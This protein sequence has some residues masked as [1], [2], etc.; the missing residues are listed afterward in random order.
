MNEILKRSLFGGIYVA[1]LLAATLF[2]TYTTFAL[3]GVMSVICFFEL[4]KMLQPAGGIYSTTLLGILATI[5]LSLY[6]FQEQQ[7]LNI[8]ASLVVGILL[9]FFQHVLAKGS[10]LSSSKVSNS[11]FSFGYIGLP[12]SLTPWLTIDSYYYFTPVLLVGIM[13]IIWSNDTFAYLI[14]RSFGKHRLHER[15]SPKKSVEG[16]IGGWIFA[17]LAGYIFYTYSN[18][19]YTLTDWLIFSSFTTIGGTF[20]DLFESA[21][22]RSAKVKDS[23][24]FIPGHG[25]LLDRI[26]SLLFV[27]PMV[28]LYLL[29]L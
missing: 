22:K 5:G 18:T 9:F 6:Q 7:E 25:G 27:V 28:W 16:F 1:V 19:E 14:G 21:L 10:E 3:V 17:L 29:I 20:G 26:D 2:S 4:R 13:V 12:L 23:G 15:L 11:L 8:S 24:S